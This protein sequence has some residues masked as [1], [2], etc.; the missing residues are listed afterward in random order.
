VGALDF[1]LLSSLK[2]PVSK[3]GS[4]V[5]LRWSWGC[6]VGSDCVDLIEAE[7]LFLERFGGVFGGDATGD[8]S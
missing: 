1:L 3:D 2:S 5:C 6:G 7:L 4:E 8:L